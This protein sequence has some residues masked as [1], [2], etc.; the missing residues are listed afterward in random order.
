MQAKTNHLVNIAAAII[1]LYAMYLNATFVNEIL[2]AICFAVILISPIRYLQRLKIPFGVALILVLILAVGFIVAIAGVVTSSV[3]E[4]IA[5]LSFMGEQVT[6]KIKNFMVLIQPVLDWFDFDLKNLNILD[7]LRE[8]LSTSQLLRYANILLS[9]VTDILGTWSFIILTMIFMLLNTDLFIDK[10]HNS[11]QNT[12]RKQ[13]IVSIFESTSVYIQKKFIISL[14]TA[15]LVY[16]LCLVF[17]FKFASLWAVLTLFLNFIPNIGVFIVAVPMVIQAL[18]LMDFFPAVTFSSILVV[19][20]FI[21]GNVVEPKYF[22]K[23]LNVNTLVVWLGLIFWNIVLGPIGMLLSVPLTMT[24]KKIWEMSAD[25]K[26][27]AGFLEDE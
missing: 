22:A 18:L 16:L 2:L 10:L 17:G 27:L 25:Y 6:G 11:T 5:N 7:K 21:S 23:S 8:I 13:Q 12:E 24:V 19:I 15:G 1:I 4:F 3:R 20:H 26:N 14:G 9:A